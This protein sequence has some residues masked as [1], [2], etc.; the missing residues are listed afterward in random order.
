MLEA[1]N[2]QSLRESIRQNFDTEVSLAIEANPDD[3]ADQ[4]KVFK[5]VDAYVRSS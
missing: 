2:F 5:L 1:E 3:L 4:E